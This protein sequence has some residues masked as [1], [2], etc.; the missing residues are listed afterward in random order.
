[1]IQ[2]LSANRPQLSVIL[3]AQSCAKQTLSTA[4]INRIAHGYFL[5]ERDRLQAGQPVA[6]CIAEE[7]GQLFADEV[8]AAVGEVG[9]PTD[10]A[11][12]HDRPFLTESLLARDWPDA[13]CAGLKRFRCHQSKEQP[14]GSE[15]ARNNKESK[16]NRLSSN[17]CSI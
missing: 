10:Q 1:V 6:A 4:Q 7:D 11:R 14:A 15:E 16:I 13:S 9:W 17:F 3:A 5:A 8:E 2:E 12:P